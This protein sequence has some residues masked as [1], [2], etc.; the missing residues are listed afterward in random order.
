M[1]DPLELALLTAVSCHAGAGDCTQVSLLSSPQELIF[2]VLTLSGLFS[3]RALLTSLS[4]SQL[5]QSKP[6]S[7]SIRP[8][9]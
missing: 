4:S 9:R 6:H 5:L 1:S 2:K 7:V 3:L 8:F